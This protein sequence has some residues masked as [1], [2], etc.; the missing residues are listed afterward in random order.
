MNAQTE[1]ALAVAA[2]AVAIDDD[3]DFDAEL[4]SATQ[5]SLGHTR[6]SCASW[7]PTWTERWKPYATPILTLVYVE[8]LACPSMGRLPKVA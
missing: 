1:N 3:P 6:K 2:D 8:D 4:L 7:R 5:F